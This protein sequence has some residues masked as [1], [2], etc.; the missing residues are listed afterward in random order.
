MSSNQLKKSA[1]KGAKLTTLSTVISGILLFAQLII[2]GRI[3]GPEEYGLFAMV[4]LVIQFS[5]IF[6]NMGLS[7]AIIQKKE[8]SKISLSSLYWF[9]QIMGW[10]IFLIVFTVAPII[11]FFFDN[12]SLIEM[13]RVVSVVFLITPLFIQFQTIARKNL[14]FEMIALSEILSVIS[15]FITSMILVL[16]FEIGVWVLI[17]SYLVGIIVKAVVWLYVEIKNK[18]N[19]PIF[20]FSFN[21]IKSYLSFGLY[22]AGGGIANYFNSRVDQLIIGLV[23]SPQILGLYSMSMNLVMQPTQKINPIITRISLPYF[24]KLQDNRE[25]LRKEYLLMMKLL[26]LINAPIY[27]GLVAVAPVAIPIFLGETWTDTVILIQILSIYVLIRG[28]GNASGSLIVA[29]GQARWSFYW[30]IMI[31]FIMPPIVFV[32]AQSENIL[33]VCIALVGLQTLLFFMNYYLRIVK[34][35]GKSLK[36]FFTRVKYIYLASILMFIPIFIFNSRLP[37]NGLFVLIIQVITGAV[38][39]ISALY[40]LERTFLLKFKSLIFK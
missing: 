2:V 20:R 18:N 33:Y 38:I 37:Y 34:I 5:N 40:L 32:S 21:S 29:S 19:L 30:N 26:S 24:S 25:E 3:I 11:A 22:R 4:N 36:G 6:L 12:Q 7:D 23:F 1:I 13:I 16:F 31:L 8:T 27:I 39:Y 35:I 28:Y 14:K 9:N 15:N 10:C 17:I